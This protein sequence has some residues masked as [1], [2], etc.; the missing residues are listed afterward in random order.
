MR[1]KVRAAPKP[2]ALMQCRCGC[3]EFI[4]TRTGVEYV[5]GKT[6]GGTKTLICAQCLLKGDRVVIA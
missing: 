3:R 6:R 5:N 1:R 4:E 2:A